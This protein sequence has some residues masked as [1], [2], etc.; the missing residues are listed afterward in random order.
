MKRLT[1]LIL[2]NGDPPSRRLFD[3]LRQSSHLLICADGGANIAHRWG[4]RPD[5]VIGDLDSI[6]RTVIKALPSGIVQRVDEQESTDLEKALA[7]C[8]RRRVRRVVVLGATGGRLDHA[9]GNLS[10][11]LKFSIR[12]DVRFVDDLGEVRAAGRGGMLKVQPGTTVSLLPMTRCTGVTTR[13]LKW[14]LSRSVLQ[15]G[16]RESTSN[17]VISSR[18]SL[19]VE[20]GDLLIFVVRRR[21]R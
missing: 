1:A 14:N 18:A 2:A 3:S 16:V 10:A 15:W 9:A 8:Q 7:L 21:G 20:R 11:L 13:G 17:V 12:M 19:R 5:L 6:H 4:V